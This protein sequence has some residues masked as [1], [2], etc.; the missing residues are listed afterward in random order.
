MQPTTTK[1]RHVIEYDG[2][3]TVYAKSNKQFENK[4]Q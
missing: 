2:L 3:K 1:T 4:P